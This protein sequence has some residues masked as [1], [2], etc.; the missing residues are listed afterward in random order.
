MSTAWP[1]ERWMPGPR[2]LW[3]HTPG[4][5]SAPAWRRTACLCL[6]SLLATPLLLCFFLTPRTLL[7][8][9][10]NQT[11]VSKKNQTCSFLGC[12]LW[13]SESCYKR[14]YS[15][16]CNGKVYCRHTI[17]C[18]CSALRRSLKPSL[19]AAGQLHLRLHETLTSHYMTTSREKGN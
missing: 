5:T 10:N 2:S 7:S 18:S 6:A 1:K 19:C 15:H 8:S 9:P 14:D 13:E 3:R 4:H 12:S 16:I 11:C 17:E